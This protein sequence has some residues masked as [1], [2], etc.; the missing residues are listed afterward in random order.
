M[1]P[2]SRFS[3]HQLV[4]DDIDRDCGF[5]MGKNTQTL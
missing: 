4:R 5:L 3:K 1:D 2:V